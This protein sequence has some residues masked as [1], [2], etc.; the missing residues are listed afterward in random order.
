MPRISALKLQKNRK[1]VNIY[2][3]DAY[4]TSLD[5]LSVAKLGLKK[6]ME[7]SALEIKRLVRKHKLT[8]LLD[9]ATRFLAYRPRTEQ[10]LRTRLLREW[11]GEVGKPAFRKLLDEVIATLRQRGLLDDRAFG[12]W[13]INQRQTFRPKGTRFLRAELRQKG[14]SQEMIEELLQGLDDYAAAT[15]AAEKRLRSV[16]PADRQRARE[17][18]IKYLERRGFA[19]QT[20]RRVVDEKLPRQY[21]SR[22]E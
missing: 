17:K 4:A 1:R 6:G 21:N 9:R 3:D 10:E 7:L 22:E 20:I 8:K 12:Q 18:L 16:S 5:L 15:R 11:R 13:W 14:V 19:W 2:V